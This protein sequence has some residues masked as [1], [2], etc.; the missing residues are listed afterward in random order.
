MEAKYFEKKDKTPNL[1]MKKSLLFSSC[2]TEY[3]K[4]RKTFYK[5]PR[6]LLTFIVQLISYKMISVRVR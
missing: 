4:P 2:V 3:D 1:P 5:G 6:G